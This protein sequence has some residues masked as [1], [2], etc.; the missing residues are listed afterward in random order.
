ME[1]RRVH[2]AVLESEHCG[3]G[4]NIDASTLLGIN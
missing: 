1:K 3:W 2:T 4:K